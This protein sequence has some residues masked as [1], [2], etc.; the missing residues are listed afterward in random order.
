MGDGANV[1]RLTC[2]GNSKLDSTHFLNHLLLLDMFHA[3]CVDVHAASLP[4][5]TAKAGYVCPTCSV[6]TS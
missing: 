5:H 4:A 6:S 1:L 3:E 2:L